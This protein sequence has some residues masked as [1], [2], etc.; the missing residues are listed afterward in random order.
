MHAMPRYHF[1][2]REDGRSTRDDEGQV[3]ANA[4]AARHEAV[5]AGAEIARDAFA[6]GSADQV[7]V[8]VRE[9]NTPILKISITLKI[10]E[11]A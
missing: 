6:A 10:E 8:D 3:F 4:S 11:S 9:D 5:E 7:V 2:I 1:D